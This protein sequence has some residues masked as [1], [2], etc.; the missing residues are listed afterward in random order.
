MRD[1]RSYA[2]VTACYWMFTLTDGALRMLVLLHLHGLGFDPLSLASL[3]LFYEFFGIVTNWVGGWLASRTGLKLTLVLGLVLQIVAL[4]M[5]A[6][7]TESWLTVPYVMAA[8]ALSGI[9]KDLTKM[10]SK[11]YI[12]LVVPSGDARGLLKWVAVLTGSKNALKGVGFFLGGALL[13]AV[14]FRAACGWMAAAIGLVLL[15]ALLSLGRATGKSKA[16]PKLS[17]WSDEPRLNWL[18]GARLFLFGS[19]DVWFV[20]AL[21]VFLVADLDWDHAQVGAFLA[22]WVI[23]YGFVQAAAPKFAVGRSENLARNLLVWKLALLLPLGAILALV[24]AEPSTVVILGLAVFG[25][26]FATD[27]ALHSYLVL[28]YSREDDVAA[29]V[30]FYYMANAAGRLIG[31]LLSGLLFQYAGEGVDGFRA[32]VIASGGFVVA[33]VALTLPLTTRRASVPTT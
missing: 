21:P 28:A 19:R 24:G 10:S 6:V 26:L 22:A 27:S 5:L 30:G 8:Q 32:C 3:F 4:G 15:V 11:S 7:V 2:I 16:K 33:S 31:T 17:L 9:A 12:K 29:R 14:G 23:G 13:S 25:F 1:V 20:V 18:A